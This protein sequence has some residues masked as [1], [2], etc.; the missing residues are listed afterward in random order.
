MDTFAPTKGEARRSAAVER[1]LRVL[2]V[3]PKHAV[4]GHAHA[5]RDI[6]RGLDGHAGFQVGLEAIDP[7]LPGR[8][9]FLTEW[10]LI[11]SLV[12]PALYCRKLFRAAARVDVLHVFAAAHTAFLFGALPALVIAKWFRRPLILNYHD[13]RAEAH[14]RWWGPLLRW[15]ARRSTLLVFPSVY[16]QQVFRRRGFDGIVVRQH[17]GNDLAM[18]GIGDAGGGLGAL[19]DQRFHLR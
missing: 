18:A 8:W 7:R 17:C 11:R 14:F 13:G 9:R 6:V 1:P 12:R 15:A 3:A 2:I 16:L 5:A 19:S 10:K 4:G